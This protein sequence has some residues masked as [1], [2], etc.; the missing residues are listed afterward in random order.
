[1]RIGLNLL[2]LLPG[3]VGGTETYASELLNSLA[4]IESIDEYYIYVNNESKNFPLPNSPRFIRVACPVA[5]TSRVKRYF[6]EQAILP[7]IA[8]KHK[9]QVLH[10][11][12]YVGP[13][14]TFQ[15]HIIT[16]HDANFVRLSSLMSRIKRWIYGTVIRCA[17]RTCDHVITISEFS[18]KELTELLGV[19]EDKMSVIHH[20]TPLPPE[21]V[22]P[23]TS[24]K[25]PRPY[26]L[27]LG[28]GSRHKNIRAFTQAFARA[29]GEFPHHLVIAGHLQ[30][31]FDGLPEVLALKESGRILI[32]GFLSNQDLDEAFRQADLFVFPTLYEGF[33]FPILEAQ[34]RGVPVLCSKTASLPEIGGSSVAY[35]DPSSIEDMTLALTNLLKHPKLLQE[36]ASL[37]EVNTQRFTWDQTAKLTAGLYKI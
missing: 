4:K 21:P 32:T 8:W 29:C 36:L 23:R 16:I 22:E 25:F 26:I 31:S 24:T 12:G 20:G 17:A 1:M 13:I 30:D 6:F 27:T 28:G 37:G 33:G 35:F 10:S 9:I 18:K 11:L 2:Y 5:A 7:L 14:I 19:P 3:Q 15:N 34:M